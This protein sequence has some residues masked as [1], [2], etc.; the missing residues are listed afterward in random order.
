M[1]FFLSAIDS[2]FETHCLC[3]W[4]ITQFW[5]NLDCIKELA[6]W[7]GK[8]SIVIGKHYST[9]H[10][11]ASEGS[12][13]WKIALKGELGCKMNLGYDKYDYEFTYKFIWLLIIWVNMITSLRVNVASR[14][15]ALFCSPTNVGTRYHIK[16]IRSISHRSSPLTRKSSFVSTAQSMT[17]QWPLQ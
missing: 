5:N 17:S 2:T 3:K 6:E 12:S 10:E 9:N 4:L 11:S 13:N 8:Q 15:E 16:H 1:S 7:S 14:L